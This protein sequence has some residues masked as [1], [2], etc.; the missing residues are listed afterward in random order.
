M[1]HLSG[2]PISQAPPGTGGDQIGGDGGAGRGKPHCSICQ[3]RL[4]GDIVF[5]DETGDVPE[6]RQS[7]T[8]CAACDEAVHWEM[9]RS[10]VQGPLRARIA[11]GVVAAERSPTSVHALATGLREINWLPVL[12]WAF[13]IVMVLHLFLLVWVVSLVAH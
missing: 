12:L 11:V 4:R 5:L 8:L 3:R 9:E 10:P 7:W 1:R 6:P 13:G 2:D